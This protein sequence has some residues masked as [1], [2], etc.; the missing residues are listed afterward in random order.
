MWYIISKIINIKSNFKPLK[1][2]CF[3]NKNN[4]KLSGNPDIINILYNAF[5][6]ININEYVKYI[7]LLFLCKD[8]LETNYDNINVMDYVNNNKILKCVFGPMLGMD[9]MRLSISSALKP[10][11]QIA[12]NK[13]YS[14]SPESTSITVSPTNDSLFGP[15]EMYLKSRG[16]LIVKNASLDK[17]NI[18]NGKIKN[19][20]ISG[21]DIIANEYVMALSLHQ[22]NKHLCS[23][24]SVTFTNMKKLENNLQL[25]FTINMYFTKTISSDCLHVV[26]IDEPWQPIIQRKKWPNEVMQKCRK[27]IQEVWNVGF[28]DYVPDKES[29]KILRECSREEAIQYGIRQIIKSRY[30]NELMSLNKVKYEDINAGYDVWYQFINSSTNFPY[31][32]NTYG[33]LIADLN[34]KILNFQSL[35]IYVNHFSTTDW[36]TS[37]LGRPLAVFSL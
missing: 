18:V 26:L 11:L 4:I 7:D 34:P 15:W 36:A 25:Y 30:F 13:Y 23:Y 31:T 9:A 5:Q 16:V 17:I 32:N 14:Y 35:S 20:V 37:I 3:I 2:N 22:I 21:K 1:D 33:N 6:F 28:L 24:N 12:D 29:G 10:L 19:I 8:R 27:D